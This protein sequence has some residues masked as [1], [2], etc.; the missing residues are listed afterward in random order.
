MV[1]FIPACF[2]SLMRSS[3]R[4]T[5]HLLDDIVDHQLTGNNHTD[6]YN[7]SAGTPEEFSN[8]STRIDRTDHIE[9][10]PSWCFI[11]FVGFRQN[12]VSWLTKHA[13]K[14]TG[15]ECGTDTNQQL[16][17]SVR[18]PNVGENCVKDS[19]KDIKGNL[20]LHTLFQVVLS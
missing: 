4:K 3:R 13:S 14:E 8:S 10:R 19:S 17:D 2:L 20:A 16:V 6:M 9:K 15:N 1:S 12:H 7:T 18:C 5:Q 11:L